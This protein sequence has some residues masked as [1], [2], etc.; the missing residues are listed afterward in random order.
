[1]DDYTKA[2]FLTAVSARF[3]F[4]DLAE[5]MPAMEWVWDNFHVTPVEFVTESI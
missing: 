2:E 1:M 3:G 5:I 4:D